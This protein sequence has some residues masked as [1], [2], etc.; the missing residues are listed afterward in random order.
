M[1]LRSRVDSGDRLHEDSNLFASKLYEEN[2]KLSQKLAALAQEMTHKEEMLELLQ[3]QLN[4][5][6]EADADLERLMLNIGKGGRESS[7]HVY[8]AVHI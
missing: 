3:S 4:L 2:Q 8:P 5:L 6:A 1:Q 7:D